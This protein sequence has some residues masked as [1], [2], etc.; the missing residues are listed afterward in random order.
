MAASGTRT[1][2][3]GLCGKSTRSH[4]QRQ[5]LRAIASATRT[6]QRHL[7]KPSQAAVFNAE[8][9]SGSIFA[10]VNFEKTD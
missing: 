8:I 1:N 5:L 3:I 4:K 7:L 9:F 10:L 2:G 6:M